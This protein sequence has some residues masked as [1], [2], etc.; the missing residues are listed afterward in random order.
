MSLASIYKDRVAIARSQTGKTGMFRSRRALR[1]GSNCAPPSTTA[2]SG[3]AEAF[4]YGREPF[5]DAAGRVHAEGLHVR[6][7]KGVRHRRVRIEPDDHGIDALVIQHQFSHVRMNFV[8]R[9]GVDVQWIGDGHQLVQVL[10]IDAGLHGA[11]GAFG[12]SAERH[13]V[14][15]RLDGVRHAPRL[16]IPRH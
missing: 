6:L 13:A 1:K 9:A 12:I 14:F 5:E 10:F 16:Q 4:T 8:I 15:V 7:R 3:L 11:A 2:T